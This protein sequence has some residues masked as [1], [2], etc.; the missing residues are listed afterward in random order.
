MSKYFV[1][2]V[3]LAQLFAGAA[4]AGDDPDRA[5]ALSLIEQCKQEAQAQGAG[6][7]DA[8]VRDCID[9]RMEYEKDE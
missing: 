5:A 2:T 8:Y 6:D 9:D 1:A 7:I 4:I 3:V